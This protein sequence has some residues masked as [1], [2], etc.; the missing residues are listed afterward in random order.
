MTLCTI[1]LC[2]LLFILL[3]PTQNTYADK[4]ESECYK[5][6]PLDRISITVFGHSDLSITSEISSEGNITFPLLG[7]VNVNGM[8]Q[9]D[10]QKSIKSMLE[11]DYLQSAEV[12][13]DIIE[14]LSK[15]VT[16]L[17]KV[18]K[19]GK[20]SLAQ[21]SRLIDIISLA[22][23]VSMVGVR[24]ILVIR[25][26]ESK[27]ESADALNPDQRNIIFIDYK[28]LFEDADF[29][30]NIPIKNKDIINVLGESKYPQVADYVY[31]Y[32]NYGYGYG[33]Y[34]NIHFDDFAF[35][36]PKKKKKKTPFVSSPVVGIKEDPTCC[37]VCKTDDVYIG[38]GYVY[39]KKC[40][41]TEYNYKTEDYAATKN[42]L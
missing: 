6:G 13:V 16:I 4:N 34:G 41:R 28:N 7:I 27:T 38:S 22:G 29:S 35:S 2:I 11:K 24:K 25:N 12:S 1:K 23:G 32:N 26:A 37:S 17:G 10:L 30:L 15:S 39:C 36:K 5:L 20:Y 31:K 8:C 21:P 33:S 3:L 40:K 9:Q 19:P 18:A 14:R 42:N